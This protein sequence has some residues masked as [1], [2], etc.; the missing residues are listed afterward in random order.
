MKIFNSILIS[1]A[2]FLS[3]IALIIIGNIFVEYIKVNKEIK[4]E[5][6]S[7]IQDNQQMKQLIMGC[8]EELKEYKVK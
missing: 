3:I 7:L 4:E 2:L 1:M 8:L 6:W 5:N